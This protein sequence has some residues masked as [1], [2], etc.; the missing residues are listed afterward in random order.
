VWEGALGRPRP[1]P[2]Q[3][4]TCGSFWQSDVTLW[5]FQ[6]A[7]TL[8]LQTTGPL[9]W[10]WGHPEK[11]SPHLSCWSK[12][13][14]RKM[15]ENTREQEKAQ[16]PVGKTKQTKP[17]RMLSGRTGHLWG[18]WGTAKE[19]SICERALEIQFTLLAEPAKFQWK[20]KKKKKKNKKKF[21]AAADLQ[22]V[23][24][25]GEKKTRLQTPSLYSLCVGRRFYYHYFVLFIS[26]IIKILWPFPEVSALKTK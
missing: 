6:S 21:L 16:S 1:L 15:F 23:A 20:T 2:P 9:G 5:G 22:D 7:S 3:K 26:Y 11:G 8:E 18:V 19:A 13:S 17:G 12:E 4:N 25:E 10:G 14:R 24:W